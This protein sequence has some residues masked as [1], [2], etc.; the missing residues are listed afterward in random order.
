MSSGP[1]EFKVNQI[2]FDLVTRDYASSK[3]VKPTLE[4]RLQNHFQIKTMKGERG[5]K[6]FI[7]CD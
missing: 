4:S 7:C 2:Y 3:S 6:L 5:L 1:S